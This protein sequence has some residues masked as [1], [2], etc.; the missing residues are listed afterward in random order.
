MTKEEIDFGMCTIGK[1]WDK[2]NELNETV[3]K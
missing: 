2:K 3:L 1:F